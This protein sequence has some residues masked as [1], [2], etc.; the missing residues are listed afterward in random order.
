MS[1]NAPKEHDGFV[2]TLKPVPAGKD[3]FGREP[4]YRMRL[5]LKRLLRCFGL[6]CVGIRRVTDES[7]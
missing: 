6:K 4:V 5:A 1:A 2:I 3:A 7:D